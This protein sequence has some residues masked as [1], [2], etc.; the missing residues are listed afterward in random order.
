MG[1]D[2]TLN[3]GTQHPHLAECAPNA[4]RVPTADSQKVPG[5]IA[6]R[7]KECDLRSP[8]L[9]E[10][11]HRWYQERLEEDGPAGMTAAN[12]MPSKHTTTMKNMAEHINT[13][14]TFLPHSDDQ[15]K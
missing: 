7:R 6:R 2:G 14:N 11:D 13:V 4:P 8:A 12:Y 3:I 1:L 15:K 5:G 10:A 9:W